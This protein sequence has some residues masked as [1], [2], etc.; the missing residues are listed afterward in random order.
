MANL[1]EGRPCPQ[2]R[3]HKVMGLVLPPLR[4]R[5][6]LVATSSSSSRQLRGADRTETWCPL[7]V[8]DV[9]GPTAGA[10]GLHRVWPPERLGEVGGRTRSLCCRVWEPTVHGRWIGL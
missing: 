2:P 5:E 7:D 10:R 3:E 4:G 1:R 9:R 8:S 6:Q